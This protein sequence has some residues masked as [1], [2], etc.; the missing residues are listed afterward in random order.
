MLEV[1]RNGVPFTSATSTRTAWPETT[2][3]AVSCGVSRPTSRAKWF[4]V[5]AATTASGRPCSIATAAAAETLPSPPATPS[6]LARPGGA[7]AAAGDAAAPAGHPERLP[8]AGRRRLTEQLDD[9]CLL[10]QL[11]H[12]GAG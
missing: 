11:Q 10:G 1:L 8:P 3:S 7:A 9:P 5:P 4:H 6:A 12:L 2:A